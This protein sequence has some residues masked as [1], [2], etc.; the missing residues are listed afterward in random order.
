METIAQFLR[1]NRIF[2]I[3]TAEGSQ[4]RVRPFG[5]VCIFGGRLYFGTGNKKPVS[6]QMKE[7]P[8]IEISTTTPDG[9]TW[10]RLTAK[11]VAHDCREARQAML[12]ATPSISG[13]YNSDDGVFE[14]FYLQNATG[15]IFSRNGQAETHEF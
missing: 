13:I 10:L 4:P 14:V 2:Y 9:A 5:A 15:T 11:A 7:N 3:A 1:D 8:Q 6:K 12:D